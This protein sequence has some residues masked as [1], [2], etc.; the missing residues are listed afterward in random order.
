[1]EEKITKSIIVKADAQKVYNAWSNFENF[2]YF[3]KNIKSVEMMGPKTSQWEMKGPLGVDVKWEAET[4]LQE[5]GKRIGWSTKDREEGNLTTS[6]QVSFNQLNANE[7]EVVATVHYQTRAGLPG[8]VVARLMGDPEEK[9]EEDLYNFKQYIEAN[10][11][12]GMAI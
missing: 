7:T 8:E 4:T 12:S 3:M 6:G 1:M 10:N 5:P 2:P 11:P 9:L